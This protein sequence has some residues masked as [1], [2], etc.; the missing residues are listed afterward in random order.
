VWKRTGSHG[1]AKRWGPIHDTIFFYSKSKDFLWNKTFEAYDDEYLRKF[2]RFTDERGQ[3]RFV[4][5]T[6]A[7]VR[8]GDSG[9]PWKGVN[10]TD[11]GRHWAVPL[12]A[13]RRAYPETDIETLTTQEKLD[14]LDNAG[15]VY[16]PPR[17]SVP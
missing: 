7:G 2:Y 1:G 5:L 3:H 10:P 6:G 11:S 4:T 8:K 15:L 16:W 14:L 17:G 13:L 9:Q 12:G